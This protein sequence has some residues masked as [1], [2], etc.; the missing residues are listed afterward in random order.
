MLQLL[1]P[2]FG[3]LLKLL[4]LLLFYFGLKLLLRCLPYFRL[5][6]KLLLLLGL[7]SRLLLTDGLRR[8]VS[9][10]RPAEVLLIG[11]RLP[12]ICATLRPH[13]LLLPLTKIRPPRPGSLLLLLLSRICR[14][15]WP[16]TLRLPLAGRLS[17]VLG[18]G[19]PVIFRRGTESVA[20]IPVLIIG[21][22]VSEISSTKGFSSILFSTSETKGK[23]VIN[24]SP[25]LEVTET[26]S[27]ARAFFSYG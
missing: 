25:V 26:R 6:L 11:S 24:K 15:P 1:L 8:R 10:W 9:S 18:V 21:I 17:V 7:G 19:A 5:L 13:P 16:G 2:Y 20:I 27:N 4:L 14:P 22:H 12:R 23:I 3:L